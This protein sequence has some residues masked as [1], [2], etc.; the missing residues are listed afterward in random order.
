MILNDDRNGNIFQLAGEA[1]TQQQLVEYLN[2]TFGTSLVYKEMSAEDYLEFQK[3]VNGEFLGTVIA[4]I[5][6][7]IRN[8]EFNIDSD[9]QAA[10]G[11]QHIRWENYFSSITD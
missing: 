1:I 8:G 11:R 10:A 3:K 2:N 9:Y 7:K 4:G 5:Y 6:T